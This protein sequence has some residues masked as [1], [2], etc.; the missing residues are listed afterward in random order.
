MVPP[1]W[2]TVNEC[3]ERVAAFV[4]SNFKVFVIAPEPFIM[5]VEVVEPIKTPL[6]IE[7]GK[8]IIPPIVRD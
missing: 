4:W 1:V 6:A 7:V 2:S 3:K 5:S 8:L